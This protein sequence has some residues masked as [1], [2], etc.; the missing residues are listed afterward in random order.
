MLDA[1]TGAV[2]WSRNAGTDSGAPTPTWG[3]AGSPLVLDDLV[4]VA[5]SGRLV[6]Y[7]LATGTPRWTRQSGGAGYSSAHLSTID[8]V[9]RSCS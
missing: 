8:G 2:V 1:K 4:I 3:F 7:D 6:A 5:A 9:G